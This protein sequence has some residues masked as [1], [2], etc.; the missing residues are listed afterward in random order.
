MLEQVSKIY[1]LLIP[2]KT[3]RGVAKY[4]LQVA[5]TTM[6]CSFLQSAVEGMLHVSYSVGRTCSTLTLVN[7]SPNSVHFRS[8]VEELIEPS[9]LI[10][11][12][13]DKH[14]FILFSSSWYRSSWFATSIIL[15]SLN[16]CRTNVWTS[17]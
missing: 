3:G 7:H 2:R 14:R 9:T 15:P 17:I 1:R 10:L 16:H 13:E 8:T 4:M 5:R 6:S 11:V 12:A